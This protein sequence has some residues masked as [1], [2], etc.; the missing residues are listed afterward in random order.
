MGMP[1]FCFCVVRLGRM[2]KEMADSFA[3]NS[4]CIFGAEPLHI[5]MIANGIKGDSWIVEFLS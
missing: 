2:V 4:C 5:M 3:C 1:M